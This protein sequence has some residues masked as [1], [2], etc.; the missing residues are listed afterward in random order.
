[1]VIVDVKERTIKYFDSM[2]GE[3]PQCQRLT[4]LFLGRETE[5]R[6]SM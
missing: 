4:E 3:N 5:K 1:M 6:C 2:G